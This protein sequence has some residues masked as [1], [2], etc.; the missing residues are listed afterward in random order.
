MVVVIVVVV[1]VMVVIVIVALY[2]TALE[3]NRRLVDCKDFAKDGKFFKFNMSSNPMTNLT[4]ASL[5]CL[6]LHSTRVFNCLSLWDGALRVYESCNVPT[7]VSDCKITREMF[8]FEQFTRLS[9]TKSICPVAM[10]MFQC[11]KFG[12]ERS[13]VYADAGIPYRK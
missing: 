13:L 5:N 11:S 4:L 10:E 8:V 7:K 1:V 6:A 2:I 12:G 9:K 3:R